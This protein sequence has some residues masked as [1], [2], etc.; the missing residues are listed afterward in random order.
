M[1]W[2]GGDTV[3]VY[4]HLVA[5]TAS[6]E[7]DPMVLQ[8]ELR[9]DEMALTLLDEDAAWSLIDPVAGTLKPIAPH[10]VT[11]LPAEGAPLYIRTRPT[12]RPHRLLALKV[13]ERWQ[14]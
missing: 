2:G 11:R 3:R 5:P 9:R 8:V 6:S 4:R 10:L 12:D 7:P 1:V 13:P 14:P